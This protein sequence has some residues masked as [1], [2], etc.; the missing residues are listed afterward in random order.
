MVD[1]TVTRQEAVARAASLVD[2]GEYIL[3]TGN[4][5]P[6]QDADGNAVDLPFTQRRAPAPRVATAPASRSAG[7][8]RSFAISRASTQAPG[9]P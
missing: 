9:P 4:Y 6:S 1:I 2:Q 8:T 5:R 3:G 7:A